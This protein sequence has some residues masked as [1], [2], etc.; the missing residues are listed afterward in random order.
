MKENKNEE[1]GTCSSPNFADGNLSGTLVMGTYPDVNLSEI[2]ETLLGY[3]L[4]GL[5]KTEYYKQVHSPQTVLTPPSHPRQRA[6]LPKSC[7]FRIQ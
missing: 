5:Y 6:S 1:M 4:Q 3:V 2:R 7:C